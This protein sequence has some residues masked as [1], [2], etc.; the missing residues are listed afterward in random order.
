MAFETQKETL[1]DISEASRFLGASISTINRWCKKTK[2][3][4][5]KFPFFQY[6]DHSPRLF[7]LQRL[8]TW[9]NFRNRL[10]GGED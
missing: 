6:C 3:G 4:K 5:M 1:V 8:A 2:K 10:P 9:R 7:S